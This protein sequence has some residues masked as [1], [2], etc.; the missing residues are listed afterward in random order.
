MN[1][2]GYIFAESYL[3]GIKYFKK[4]QTNGKMCVIVIQ[5]EKKNK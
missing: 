4:Q 1:W 5:L 2:L 3:S